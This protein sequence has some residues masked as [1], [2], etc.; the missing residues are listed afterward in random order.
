MAAPSSLQTI[1][2]GIAIS[3]ATIQPNIAWG[4]PSADIKS[5]IVMKGPT[6]IMFDMFRAVACT[7]PKRLSR[8]AASFSRFRDSD[9]MEIV[10]VF[11]KL[12][13]YL[14]MTFCREFYL[15]VSNLCG[16]FAERF[17]LTF[18]FGEKYPSRLKCEVS[19]REILLIDQSP[20]ISPTVREGSAFRRR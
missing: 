17:C 13:S 6:P 4:P 5:G 19:W 18:S 11:L 9:A 1:P 8:G 16:E 10:D 15:R 2:S 12:T 3:T 7:S 14:N 20:G